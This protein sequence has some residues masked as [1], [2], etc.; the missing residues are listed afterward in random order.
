M[1]A[2]YPASIASYSTKENVVDVIDA[3]HPN[4]LQDEVIAIES[5]L[6]ITPNIST[7][8]SAG[9][10]FNAASNPFLTVSARLANIE[11]GVV[12]DTHIQYIK[13]AGDTGN[14]ISAGAAT[15]KPLILK[16]AAS[17]SANLLELQNA[18]GT[19]LSYIDASGNFS[20]GVTMADLTISNKTANYTLALTD[21][22]AMIVVDSASAIT[23]TVPDNSSVAFP[24]GAQVHILRKGAGT[25]QVVGAGSASVVGAPGLFLRATNSSATLIKLN[26]SQSFVLVGDLSTS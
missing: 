24:Q 7:T 11:T 20:G 12:S 6:G 2:T 18:S 3:S 4:L 5:I 1:T 9:G 21:K 22:N 8:P 13:K 23:I 16:G 25:V 14:I 10:T 26:T 15:T 17:Q 19:V